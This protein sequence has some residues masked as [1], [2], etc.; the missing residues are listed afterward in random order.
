MK[1]T[2]LFPL[3]AII[4]VVFSLS[5]C[6]KGEEDPFISLRS[7][8]AR[9]TA[10]WNL[11]EGQWTQTTYDNK[12]VGENLGSLFGLNHFMNQIRKNKGDTYSV[13]YTYTNGKLHI[14]ERD[15][16]DDGTTEE[17]NYDI[18]EFQIT[19]VF[20]NDYT[21]RINTYAKYSDD[22]YTRENW[23]VNR[24]TWSFL[25]KNEKAKN[26][27]RVLLELASKYTKDKYS[28]GNYSHIE[29]DSTLY[30]GSGIDINKPMYILD[31]TRLASKE[32][33]IKLDY[34]KTEM[35]K[36][37]YELTGYMQFEKQKK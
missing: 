27:E 21:F 37:Y 6:K 29:E 14:T 13:I 25:Q 34:K 31:L 4:L 17:T 36:D 22:N 33:K 12:K 5:S 32:L 30:E 35:D 24:G 10:T 11:K 1:K 19:M 26:K 28:Y 2:A 15:T 20:N 3:M 16:Y 23:E 9:L 7:R 18:D 8:K